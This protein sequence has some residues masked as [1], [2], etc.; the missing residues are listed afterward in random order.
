[1]ADFVDI[2]LVHGQSRTVNMAAVTYGEACRIALA[3][4]EHIVWRI[5]T[6]L[7]AIAPVLTDVW[8]DDSAGT[9]LAC[10]IE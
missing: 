10:G 4:D 7:L 8:R 2:V 5:S 1:M 9:A 3:V 6:G